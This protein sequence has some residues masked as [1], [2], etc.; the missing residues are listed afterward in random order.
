MIVEKAGLRC[1]VGGHN[2][3]YWR[4]GVVMLTERVATGSDPI[5]ICTALHECAHSFQPR[6]LLALASAV[7]PVSWY[8]ELKCWASIFG[9][10]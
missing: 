7:W 8:A 5:S 2:R 3:F 9:E 1:I 6:W 4:T 10:V